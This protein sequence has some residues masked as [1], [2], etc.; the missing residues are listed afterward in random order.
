MKDFLKDILPES[1]FKLWYKLRAKLAA[2]YYRHPGSNL[3]IVAVTG[4]NG[5]TTTCHLISQILEETGEKVGMITTTTIKNG[6]SSR[7]NEMKMTT[8]DPFVLQKEIKEMVE[9][10]CKYLVLETSSHGIA[11]HRVESIPFD[12]SVMTNLTREHLDYHKNFEDY[13]KAKLWLFENLSS[14]KR[15]PNQPKVAVLNKDDRSFQDFSRVKTDRI[16]SY[17]I[18][19]GDI[20]ASSVNYHEES[21]DYILETPAGKSRVT[22]NLPGRFNVYNSLAAAGAALALGVGVGIIAQ[23]LESLK[24]VPGRMEIIEAGQDFQVIVDYA[25]TPD[26]LHQVFET[27]RPSVKG[28]LIALIGAEGR[29]SKTKRPLLGALCGQYADWTIVTNVDP[30]DEDPNSIISDV[31]KGFKR[32]IPEGKKDQRKLLKIANRKKAIRKALELARPQD[33]VLLL[34][35][36]AEQAIEFEDKKIPWDDRKVVRELIKDMTVGRE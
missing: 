36:G 3:K 16:F 8:P 26:G 4:T 28:K 29:R 12:V 10:G 34:A 6:S 17:G 22:L 33:T 15:K 31:A 11:Q 7:V 18:L 19:R 25:H 14:F 5:K 32:G 1:F 23:G 2:F 9:N 30:R 24:G 21:S 13:K 35:K 20:M 27:L